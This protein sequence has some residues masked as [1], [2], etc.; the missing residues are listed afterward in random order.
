MPDIYAQTSDGAYLQF[1]DG[2]DPA[3]I[4]KAVKN[5]LASHGGAPASAPGPAHS[6]TA[7]GNMIQAEP[8]IGGKHAM[9]PMHFDAVPNTSIGSKEYYD[10]EAP[11]IEKY[12]SDFLNTNDSTANEPRKLLQKLAYVQNPDPKDLAKLKS[13][14]YIGQKAIMQRV[15]EIRQELA[16]GGKTAPEQ[17]ASAIHGPAGGPTM[18]K[19]RGIGQRLEQTALGIATDP[20][21]AGAILAGAAFP[22]AAPFIGAG[23]AGASIGAGVEEYKT[24]DKETGAYHIA[25]GTVAGGLSMLKGKAGPDKDVT[26]VPAEKPTPKPHPKRVLAL[27]PAPADTPL[28]A[29]HGGNVTHLEPAP[30]EAEAAAEATHRANLLKQDEA[31]RTAHENAESQARRES[32]AKTQASGKKAQIEE[33]RRAQS[34]ARAKQQADAQ[35]A[36]DTADKEYADWTRQEPTEAA[37]PPNIDVPTRPFTIREDLLQERAQADAAGQTETAEGKG[38]AEAPVDGKPPETPPEVQAGEPEQSVGRDEAAQATEAPKPPRTTIRGKSKT[39][40]ATTLIPDPDDVIRAYKAGRDKLK[41]FGYGMKPVLTGINHEASEAVT[42]HES[43]PSI[44]SVHSAYRIPQVTDILAEGYD[45]KTPTDLWGRFQTY[46]TADRMI[47]EK[48]RVR[49]EIAKSTDPAEIKKYND[50]LDNIALERA[51]NP[52]LDPVSGKPLTE[53]MVQGF[54]ND[55]VVKRAIGAH[56]THIEPILEQN[57]L[58]QGGVTTGVRGKYSGAYFPAVALDESGNPAHFSQGGAN[59]SGRTSPLA[60]LGG[61]TSDQHFTGTGH[62]YESDYESVVR[63]KFRSGF[64]RAT[65]RNMHQTLL[66]KNIERPLT[67]QRVKKDASGVPVLDKSGNPVMENV[68]NPTLRRSDRGLEMNTGTATK[69][70]WETADIHTLQP[71]IGKPYS[72]GRMKSG[73]SLGTIDPSIPADVALPRRVYNEMK[74]LFDKQGKSDFDAGIHNIFSHYMEKYLTGFAEIN[75]HALAQ[76]SN[77]THAKRF[78]AQNPATAAV[79]SM[80]QIPV[81]FVR[82]FNPARFDMAEKQEA[83]Q[84]GVKAGVVPPEWPFEYRDIE[85]STNKVKDAAYNVSHA[86]RHKLYGQDGLITNSITSIYKFWKDNGLD[87]HTNGQAMLHDAFRFLNTFGETD[88]ATLQKAFRAMGAGT[89]YRTGIKNQTAALKAG[90]MVFAAGLA[91]NVVA[92]A[93]G[94]KAADEKNRWPT[95]VPGA[96]LFD[97][98]IR[99]LKSKD[100]GQVYVNIGVADRSLNYAAKRVGADAIMQGFADKMSWSQTIGQFAIDQYNVRMPL[101][102]SGPLPGIVENLSGMSTYAVKNEDNTGVKLLPNAS[103]AY[104]YDD[105]RRW[106]SALNSSLPITGTG[107]SLQGDRGVAKIKNTKAQ[108][109]NSVLKAL[110]MG[111]LH[112]AEPAGYIL[113]HQVEADRANLGKHMKLKLQGVHPQ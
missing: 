73:K 82:N 19:G 15:S 14:S 79:P 26:P 60:Q 86:S 84:E 65:E 74:P 94:F 64:D 104:P 81:E 31:E 95:Q 103:T 43:A 102:T 42:E 38:P 110:G 29:S 63:D 54:M 56:K 44:A 2:T 45:R 22:P 87:K 76:G 40:G 58:A 9:P 105:L 70:N 16:Q 47:A 46:G 113:K 69:P 25:L 59:S 36:K 37:G 75:A 108:A 67:V 80:L 109:L 93:A 100:G 12:R 13:F 7:F 6:P 4:Q 8:R 1:P 101:A 88:D 50:Q 49:A 83:M 10:A 39:T 57:Q 61:N 11:A 17:I 21:T 55:P 52:L 90:K 111:Q 18:L 71:R 99:G 68:P 85:T 107:Y 51:K 53:S 34:A 91:G 66:D 33:Q 24:G 27:P 77:V 35:A 89:F 98:P 28:S 96:R 97:I 23:Y 112:V 20:Q 106:L 78:L 30:I 48:E 62:T 41:Q 32:N 92:W 5:Y 72:Y 3:V